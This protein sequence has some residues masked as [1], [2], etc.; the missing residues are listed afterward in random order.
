MVRNW[1]DSIRSRIIS[2]L[3]CGPQ[4]TGSKIDAEQQE[5]A[6]QFCKEMGA[7]HKLRLRE[8]SFNEQW[9]Q[10]PPQDAGNLSLYDYMI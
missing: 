5:I 7:A 2:H 6:L 8:V 10:K 4:I 3:L 1:R 9:Q